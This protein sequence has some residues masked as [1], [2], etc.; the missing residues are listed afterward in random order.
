VYHLR[1]FPILLNK[2]KA[3]AVIGCRFIISDTGGRINRFYV[4]NMPE[5]P[6][7]YLLCVA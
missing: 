4:L 1:T 5:R 7:D 2:K 6:V 3:N